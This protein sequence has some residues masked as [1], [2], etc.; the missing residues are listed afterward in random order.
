MQPVKSYFSPPAFRPTLDVFRYED[1]M[2]KKFQQRRDVEKVILD[3][4][5]CSQLEIAQDQAVVRYIRRYGAFLKNSEAYHRWLR[6]Y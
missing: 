1:W 3:P 6:N 2:W 5:R 4:K